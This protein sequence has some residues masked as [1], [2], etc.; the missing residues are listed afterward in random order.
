MFGETLYILIGLLFFGIFLASLI[1]PWVLL[2]RIQVLRKEVSRLNDHVAWLITYAREKGATIPEQ[3]EKLSPTKAG[4]SIPATL[5]IEKSIDKASIPPP[6]PSKSSKEKSEEASDKKTLLFKDVKKNFEQKFA[7]SLPVWIGG[8]A[9][10]LAGAFMVKYSIEMGFLS[11]SVRLTIGGL[12]GIALLIFGN[13]IHD[14]PHIANG[15]RISQALSGAGIAD[16]YVCLFAA[17]SFYNLIPPLAGFVGMAI[18]TTIAVV[19]SL[20]QGPPI[21]MLGMIGGFLTPAL[22]ESKE[23]SAPL[24]FIY[25]YFVLAGL[26]TVIRRKNWWFIAIPIVLATFAWVIFWVETSYSPHDGL[27]L[28]LFLIAVSGTIVFHSKK[29]MEERSNEKSEPFPLFPFLNYL[30]MG[31]A[32]LLMSAV[33]TKSHFGIMEWGLFGLLTAGGIALSYYNQKLYGFIPWL[34]VTMNVIMLLGWQESDPTILASTVMAFALLYTLSSYGLMWK[35][36]NPRSWAILGASSS[37]IYYVLAYAKFHNWIENAGFIAKDWYTEAHPWG[38]LALGLF[39]LSVFAVIQILN[40]FHGEEGTK[41]HLLT[42]YTLTATAFLSIGL[43]LGLNEEFLTIAL[44]TEILAVSWINGY[45]NIKALRFLAGLLAALFGILI[46][47]QILFK[48]FILSNNFVAIQSAIHS[49]LP[50]NALPSYWESRIPS[51]TWSFFHLGLPALLFGTSSFLLRRQR[52][53]FLIRTF[54]MTAIGLITVMTY[55]LTRHA[56]HM[57]EN[58]AFIGSTFIERGTLTN[59]FFLY[60]LG[61]LWLG[62]KFNRDAVSLSGVLLIVLALLRI[63]FFDLLIYNPL[64]TNQ[65]VGPLPLFNGLL[66]PY[67]LPILW[68]ML[69]TK[70]LLNTTQQRY[71]PYANICSFVLLFFFVSFNVTQIYHGQYLYKGGF[72]NAEVYTY[73]IAWI[74]TGIVLLFFG[75]LRQNK[76][77]RR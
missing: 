12:F 56:F 59:I 22:I 51:V 68:L 41:Q 1:L 44:A 52:D 29:A 24:L 18:V 57:N 69:A 9:L 42:A 58:L 60:G 11:P 48:I 33:V 25:L 32:I 35:A 31:G 28:G 55:Y 54:E 75:T 15:E 39:S 45:V 50:N 71:I 17:T 70:E 53:D 13:W 63:L 40:R 27:C 38:I 67:G 20:K 66:L 26:F 76:M 36:L 49:N 62:R 21:A 3:W 43:A 74:L 73:S 77:L 6:S 30:S 47:P 5:Q 46:I 34:S 61:C 14:K 16:L 7:M 72:S 2:A 19:L 65:Y 4:K 37:L 23:P 64:G 10:A 8:I